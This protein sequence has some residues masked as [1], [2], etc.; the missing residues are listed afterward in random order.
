MN[1]TK[2]KNFTGRGVPTAICQ[3]VCLD[4][5]REG[6]FARIEHAMAEAAEAEARLACFPESSLL[7]WVNAA[8]HHRACPIPGPDSD[9]LCRLA[10]QYGLYVCIGL[11]EKDG[12]RLF[13]SAIL[14]D[15]G[16]QILLKHRKINVLPELMT[17]PYSRGHEEDITAVTTPLGKIGVVICA[18]TFVPMILER[19]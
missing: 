3:I 6:N 11:D 13:G 8:A 9:R 19:V 16:G 14:I 15:P 18:D 5:D 1:K 12:D 17:P 7:G 4:G 2:G 10:K